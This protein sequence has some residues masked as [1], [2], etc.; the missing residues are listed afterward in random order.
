MRDSQTGNVTST[1]PQVYLLPLPGGP[2]H[3]SSWREQASASVATA[4]QAAAV[5][6]VVVVAKRDLYCLEI[7]MKILIPKRIRAEEGATR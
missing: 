4:A 5:V 1:T 7:N 6:V 2:P 3:L